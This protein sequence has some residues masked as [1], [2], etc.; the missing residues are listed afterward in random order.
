[1]NRRAGGYSLVELLVALALS[2][3]L[4]AGI[5][6]MYFSTSQ[7]YHVEQQTAAL[8]EHQR[9]VATFVGSVI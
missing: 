8:E 4:I 7:S 1:M 2:L 5:A 6:V 3:F 9:L